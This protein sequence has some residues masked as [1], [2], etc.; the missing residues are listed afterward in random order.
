MD[1][2]RPPRGRRPDNGRPRSQE[3][4]TRPKR[5]KKKRNWFINF[6]L[7]LLLLIGL[8]LVFN[9]QIKNFLIKWN[10][11]RYGI[12]KLSKEDVDRN[13][14]A[15]VTFDFDNV[16]SITSEG[17]LRAQLSNKRLATI[18]GIAIPSVK[19][20]LPIF[21][22]LENEALF[23]GAGTMSEAQVMGEGNYGLASHRAYEPDLLFS[24]IE[25]MAIG[26]LIYITD[27][28]NIYT[29]STTHVE[30]IQPTEV[31]WLDEVEGKK[32]ITLITCG[33]MYATTRIVVQGELQAVTSVE[34]ATKAMTDAFEM[35]EKT[36]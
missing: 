28:T 31:E 18:G 30:K 6:F 19:V 25:N 1:R 21:K 5:R 2:G 22:G 20:K 14:Q 34:K 32:L 12:E 33:D 7:F 13:L 35:E 17:I 24:P 8:A 11:D 26:D 15:D 4:R 16:E 9:N 3:S 36:Y 23:W 29:Y 27:L 10:S